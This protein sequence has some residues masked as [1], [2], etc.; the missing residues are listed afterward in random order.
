MFKMGLKLMAEKGRRQ[1]MIT[2]I[3]Q[4]CSD[5]LS[6][7]PIADSLLQNEGFKLS[8]SVR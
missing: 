5:H 4:N 6:L 2:S 8:D 7:K 3:I 1:E